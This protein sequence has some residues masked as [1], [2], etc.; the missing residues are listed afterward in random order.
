MSLKFSCPSC[1]A[2]LVF[3]SSI[4]LMSTCSFCQSLVVR[5]DL[6]IEALGKT[7]MA[8][9][10]MSVIQLGSRGKYANVSFSV[11]GRVQLKWD[12]GFWNE[13]FIAFEDGKSGWLAEAQGSLMISFLDQRFKKFPRRESIVIGDH[14]QMSDLQS[15]FVKDIRTATVCSILGELPFVQKI[16][17]TKMTYDLS[18]EEGGFATFDYDAKDMLE[19]ACYLGRWQT[20]QSLHLVSLREFEEWPASNVNNHGR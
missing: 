15:Y 3:Q 14:F 19:P 17:Q 18:S 11:M 2:E 1:G 9:E 10:D 6:D 16:G 7:S 20:I 8:H 4:S 12:G 13:W 5:R